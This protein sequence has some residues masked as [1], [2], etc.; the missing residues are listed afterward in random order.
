MGLGWI[1]G[2]PTCPWPVLRRTSLSSNE[3]NS[4]ALLRAGYLLFV[5]LYRG[6][7]GFG[8]DWSMRTCNFMGNH[9]GD[10]GDILTGV[11]HLQRT[12]M[13]GCSKRA[14]IFGESYGGY[15]TIKALS[16]PE[17]AKVFQC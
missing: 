14:G 6:T 3:L 12:G 7:L 11:A 16:D 17:G 13:H 4:L 8:D 2:G 9:A 5:P 1:H 10:L 15:M